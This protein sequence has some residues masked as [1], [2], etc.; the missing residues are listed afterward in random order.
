MLGMVGRMWVLVGRLCVGDRM[1]FSVVWRRQPFAPTRGPWRRPLLCPKFVH[2]LEVLRDV[3]YLLS[4]SLHGSRAPES[5]GGWHAH[6][7]NGPCNAWIVFGLKRTYVYVF[8]G[9]GFY[10]RTDSF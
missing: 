7:D 6:S 9:M 2:V 3:P 5:R 10:K 8:C 1:L 4:R